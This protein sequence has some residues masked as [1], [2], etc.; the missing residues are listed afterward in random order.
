MNLEN[1]CLTENEE[2][3]NTPKINKSIVQ[4]TTN[5][6]V[7]NYGK[8]VQSNVQEWISNSLSSTSQLTNK[9]QHIL[10]TETK[11][12]HLNKEIEN[13][14]TSTT[15]SMVFLTKIYI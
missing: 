3:E 2:I 4:V 11:I 13:S 15:I 7:Q 1:D 12:Q 8:S 10:N 14:S 6:Q 9:N 5:S